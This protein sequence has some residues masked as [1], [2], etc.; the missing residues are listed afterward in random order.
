VWSHAEAAPRD[1]RSTVQRRVSAAEAIETFPCFGG[2]ATVIVAGAGPAGQPSAA[3]ALVKRRLLEWHRQFSRFEPDSELSLLNGDPRETVPVS[4]VM[5]RLIGAILD[6][7]RTSGGLVDGTLV[8]EIERA[9]YAEHFESRPVP[10]AET[11]RRAPARAPAEPNPRGRWPSVSLDL[12]A[13][14]VTRPPGLRFDSGGIAKGLF[15]D[16]LAG[17]L[18][19]HPGFAIDCAGDVRVGGA[20]GLTR[21]VQVAS[22]FDDSILHTFELTAGAAAT[23]GIGRRSWLDAQGRPAHHLLDPASGRPAFTGIVQVTAVA[24]T[25][26]EAEVL[27]KT[28]LLRGPGASVGISRHGGVLVYDDGRVEICSSPPAAVGA[29]DS[30]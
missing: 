3:A 27:T 28:T 1:A 17:V 20:V 6:A 19:L 9:G 7:A 13:G 12:R 2:S 5:A 22:P 14:T 18:E 26:V 11:L 24:P 23:S 30:G 29:S 21:P 10:L 25:A 15:C 16:I 4:Q 8:G